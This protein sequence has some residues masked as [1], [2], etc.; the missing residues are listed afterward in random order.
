[1]AR[2]V[3]YYQL[4]QIAQEYN[5]LPLTS[6]CNVQCCFCSHHQN[7]A[8]IESYAIPRLT[9]EQAKEMI[10]FLN[11]E[12]KIVIGESVSRIMEGEPFLF[13]YLYEVLIEVRKHFPRTLISLTTNGS[14]FNEETVSRLTS[15]FPLEIN[16]SLNTSNPDYRRSLLKDHHGDIA[17]N[18]PLLLNK[19]SI[20]FHGSIVAMPHLTGWKDLENTI[21]Y[22]D[23]WGARTVRV[24]EPGYTRWCRPAVQPDFPFS[25]LKNFIESLEGIDCPVAIEPD[26]CVDL[27]PTIIGTISDTPARK[28]GLQKNDLILSIDGKAPFSR[29]D[30]F[31]QLKQKGNC[32]LI[33]QR[34]DENLHLFLEK[35]PGEAS[36]IVVH[37]DLHPSVPKEVRR[38]INRTQAQNPILATSTLAYPVLSMAFKDEIRAKQLQLITVK[39]HLFGGN[40]R[41]AGLLIVEDYVQALKGLAGDL[42]IL[43]PI[44]F[45]SKGRDL[46]NKHYLEIESGLGIPVTLG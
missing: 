12:Q 42:I 13:P 4:L 28:V 8:G 22:Q 36:G 38:L 29:V 17:V 31:L 26:G 20:P 39:N 14:F 11:K 44:G 27:A 33:I 2:T 18:S 1:M 5:I 3:P 41:S 35:Q 21:R 40:I 16:L 46:C 6:N 30:A 24:F 9:L 25:Q 19:Y 45:D 7:P 10:G 15:L 32:R 23:L 37:Y 34:A 43:P